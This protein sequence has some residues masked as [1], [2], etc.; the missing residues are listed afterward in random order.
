MSFHG[1]KGLCGIKAFILNLI[2][3]SDRELCMDQDEW[4]C[5]LGWTVTRT[6]FGARHYRDPRFDLLRA[7]RIAAPAFALAPTPDEGVS[8]NVAA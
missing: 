5:R 1:T 7:E 4:A 8:G 2:D 3:A 6:G